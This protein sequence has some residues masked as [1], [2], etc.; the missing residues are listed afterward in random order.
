MK[1]SQYPRFLLI[2]L[3]FGFAWTPCFGKVYYS[4]DEALVLAFGDDASVETLSLFPSDEQISQIEQLAKVKLESKLLSLFVGKKQN[5]VTGYAMIESHTVRTQP[6]TL[7]IL[8]DAG[9][10]LKNVYTLA[11]H[12]PAEY[13]TPER[14]FAQLL[15]QG[16]DELSFDKGVQGVAGAT[17]S[18]RAAL[19]SVRKVLAVY[20]IMLK[21]ANTHPNQ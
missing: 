10:N 6:E 3:L 14:W 16:I 17:L 8:L 9:G 13:Q 11:F 19:N 1:L 7:L 2:V 20:Q 12:E 15:N 5:A 21:P 18:T 4:K